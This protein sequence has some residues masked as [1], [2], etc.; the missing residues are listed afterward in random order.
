MSLTTF[1][2]EKDFE[3]RVYTFEFNGMHHTIT[4][5]VVIAAIHKTEGVQRERIINILQRLDLKNGD[6]RLLQS[7][8]QGLAAATDHHPGRGF[9]FSPLLDLTHDTGTSAA[10]LTTSFSP[11]RPVKKPRIRPEGTL[12]TVEP[13]SSSHPTPPNGLF[14]SSASGSQQRLTSDIYKVRISKGSRS[15]HY[16]PQREVFYG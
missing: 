14:N 15:E 5:N 13:L 4:T 10:P 11:S 6:S 16:L 7:L 9:F 3:N 2:K 1:F 8:R 12:C